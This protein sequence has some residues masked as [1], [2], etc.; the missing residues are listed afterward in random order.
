[1]QRLPR[2]FGRPHPNRARPRPTLYSLGANPNSHPDRRS[3]LA[4]RGGR[5]CVRVPQLGRLQPKDEG[6]GT[7]SH[8]DPLYQPLTQLG[9]QELRKFAGFLE[10]YDLNVDIPRVQ[11]VGL[12]ELPARLDLVAHQR[13]EDLVGA[14]GVLDL[15]AQHAA[16]GGIHRRLPQLPR[17][18][19]S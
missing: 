19:L 11:R 6:A 15:H 18:H 3:R 9:L 5:S 17:V 14:D 12:D 13:G 10:T 4:S 2:V 16:H 8:P 7:P 1:M